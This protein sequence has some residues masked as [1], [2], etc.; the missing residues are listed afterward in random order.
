VLLIQEHL[1]IKTEPDHKSLEAAAAIKE[2]FAFLERRGFRLARTDRDD[3]CSL[4]SVVYE[5]AEAYVAL[6]FDEYRCF[7][8]HLGALPESAQ[9]APGAGRSSRSLESTCTWWSSP[10]ASRI[11]LTGSPA[12]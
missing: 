7:F 8:V 11:P 12:H 3:R 10:N 2:A 6:R 9:R 5:S 1:A 4:D